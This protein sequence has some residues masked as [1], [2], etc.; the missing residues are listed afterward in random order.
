MLIADREAA[1]QIVPDHGHVSEDRV[2]HGYPE[3]WGLY[4]ALVAAGFHIEPGAG[5]TAWKLKLGFETR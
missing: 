2:H 1:A 4:P 5:V 3:V